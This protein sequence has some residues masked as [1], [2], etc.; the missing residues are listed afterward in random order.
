M[1]AIVIAACCATLQPSAAQVELIATGSV[2]ADARDLSGL[3]GTVAGVPH[4]RFGGWGSAVAWTGRGW[5]FVL[6]PDRGPYDGAAEYRTR[7]HVA[8]LVVDLD[9]KTV[10]CELKRTVMLT[11][12]GGTPLIGLG[13]A[14]DGGADGGARR[15]D[16]EGARLAPDGLLYISEEYG[17]RIDVFGVDGARVRRIE[18]PAAFRVEHAGAT[19]EGEMPPRNT[20]GRQPNRGFEG[21][22]LSPDGRTLWAIPQS[23]LI[24]DG[25]LDGAGKRTGVN[26]RVLA[27]D[28]G[29]GASRQFV[30]TLSTP[31]NG[32]SEVLAVDE[33]RMLVLE[34]DGDA[35]TEAERKRIY[36]AD[37]G[38]AT[39]V[40]ALGALPSK[41]L[42][43]G[44]AAA[45]KRVFIDLLD[46]AFG[47][48]GSSMP[49][50]IEGLAFGPE[51]AD[52]RRTLIVATDN[53]FKGDEPSW[54][55]VFAFE[56]GALAR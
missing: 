50:K 23:P 26:I 8:A 28:A 51:L 52:G 39:D 36:L 33:R 19:P 18:V 34:R 54:V 31:K 45:V 10:A 29:G 25:A 1:K 48:A 9:A 49:E 37:F 22:A 46:P 11:D 4:D 35:G 43:A 44:T 42:P 7:F 21:L 6:L 20:R 12:E 17:P 5:E 16:P 15:Y 56:A 38:G 30:Y 24:Q 14:L 53:D 2:P 40:S 47:L 32:V 41:E 3:S 55:W 13:A 27:V